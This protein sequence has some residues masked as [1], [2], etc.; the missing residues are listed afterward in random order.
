MPTAKSQQRRHCR[1]RDLEATIT[2]FTDLGLTVVARVSGE[3]ADIAVG[4]DG[5]HGAKVAVLTM[6]HGQGDPP[7]LPAKQSHPDAI[8]TPDAAQ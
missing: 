8:E 3:W 6:L 7:P 1:P 4:L 5:N 2:F